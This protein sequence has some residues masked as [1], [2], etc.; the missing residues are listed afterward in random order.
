MV[1]VRHEPAA[2]SGR[3]ARRDL[4]VLVAAGLVLFS[5]LVLFDVFE[6]FAAWSREHEGW[7]LD[8][9]LVACALLALG[10]ALYAVRRWQDLGREVARRT[11]AEAQA[12][13]LEGLL[14]IC[15]GCKK[16][17]EGEAWVAVEAYVAARTQAAFTH[18]I[19]PE[20]RQRLYPGLESTA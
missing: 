14:P 17:R 10:C 8:E 15:A 6:R 20:C 7:Q 5:V 13:R 18:G 4:V 3:R 9:L 12:T 2:D 16:V 11:A 1:A 19:C